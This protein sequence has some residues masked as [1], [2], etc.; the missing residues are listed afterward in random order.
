M[1]QRLSDDLFIWLI[2]S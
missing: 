2:L 1:Y